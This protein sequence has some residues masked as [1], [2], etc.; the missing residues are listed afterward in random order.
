MVGAG[1]GDSPDADV[2]VGTTTIVG[3]APTSHGTA[4]GLGSRFLHPPPT[5]PVLPG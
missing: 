5:L 3:D 1:F 4:I 2:T